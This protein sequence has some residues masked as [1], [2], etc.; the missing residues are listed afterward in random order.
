[1]TRATGHAEDDSGQS[2]EPVAGGRRLT[3]NQNDLDEAGMRD[4]ILKPRHDDR[5]QE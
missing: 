5:E 4:R 3:G 1:M 2:D